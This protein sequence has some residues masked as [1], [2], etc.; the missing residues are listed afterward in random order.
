MSIEG[1]AARLACLIHAASVHP[2]LESNSLS[3]LSL[4]IFRQLEKRTAETSARRD[5]ETVPIGTLRRS[6]AAI[7]R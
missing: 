4:A 1:W 2:E 7:G 5:D 6:N 3:V